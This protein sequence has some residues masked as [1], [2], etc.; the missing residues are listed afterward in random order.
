MP[1]NPS[2]H[3]ETASTTASQDSPNQLSPTEQLGTPAQGTPVENTTTHNGLRGW[4][5]FFTILTGIATV[6]QTAQ[7]VTSIEAKDATSALFAAIAALLALMSLVTLLL[8]KKIGKYIYITYIAFTFLVYGLIH[9]IRTTD[10]ESMPVLAKVLIDI[11]IPL[12]V[13]LYFLQSK[14]VRS[15]LSK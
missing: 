3:I 12:L 14:R 11:A 8:Q 6:G 13:S 15:T 5:L 10:T 2:N 4:L 1:P 9:D 7:I